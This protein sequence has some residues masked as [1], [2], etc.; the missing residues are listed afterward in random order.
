MLD[1]PTNHLDIAS[2]EALESALEEYDGTVVIVSHDR[3]FIDKLATRIIDM[4]PVAQGGGFCDIKVMKTGEGYAE[5]GR[6]RE[7]RASLSGAAK[8]VSSA[9]VSSS[10][11][12]YLKNK[13]ENADRR[14][15]QKRL[16]RLQA[17]AERIEK[18]LEEIEAEMN[19]EAATDY[20]RLSEL[21]EKKNAL[22][23]RLLEI[24]GEI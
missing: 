17:E 21:D 9:E 12:Q 18:E 23:E 19:G 22:E 6:D 20:A 4:I 10:K 15:A 7:R 14:N 5:L 13:K 3:Y 24:Y 16:E 1:E 2:R 8:T 11:E